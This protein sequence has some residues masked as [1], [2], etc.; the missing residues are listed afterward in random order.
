[1]CYI[2]KYSSRLRYIGKYV[3]HQI[4]QACI[5]WHLVSFTDTRSFLA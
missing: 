3:F 1:M 5:V 2:L 4:I